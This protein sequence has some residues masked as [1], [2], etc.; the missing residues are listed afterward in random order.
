M[1]GKIAKINKKFIA[2]L[3][4][5]LILVSSVVVAYT[6]NAANTELE[7]TGAKNDLLYQNPFTASGDLIKADHGIDGTDIKPGFIMAQSYI[8]YYNDRA[9]CL[10]M[11]KHSYTSD[12]T[13]ENDE[14]LAA[15]KSLGP[16]KQEAIKKIL[17]LGLEGSLKGDPKNFGTEKNPVYGKKIKN[18]TSFPI[19][20]G[21]SEYHRIY[22]NTK[23]GNG[24]YSDSE[25]YIAVQLLIWEVQRGWRKPSSLG[26]SSKPLIKAYDNQNIKNVYNT[27]VS[28]AKDIN[29]IPSFAVRE[30]EI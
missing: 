1:I 30:R 26:V 5:V 6:V 24:T 15:W 4:S 17:A 16:N 3:M 10:N 12:V 8:K 29:V 21:A 19:S 9:Y 28:K 20:Q 23:Y 14:T 22:P 25:I 18:V 13:K 27:I 2:L 7:E 11:G